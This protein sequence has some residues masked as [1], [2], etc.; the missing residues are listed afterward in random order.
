[1]D[2][3]QFNLFKQE[4]ME[5]DI[6]KM[7]RDLYGDG[8]EPGLMTR[9]ALLENTAE[10]ILKSLEKTSKWAMASFGAVAFLILETAIKFLLK[11]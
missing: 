10:N 7:E 1:M 9:T 4:E 6:K 3:G 5:K 11:I 8:R 2:T